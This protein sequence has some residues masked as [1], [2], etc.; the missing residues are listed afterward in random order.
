MCEIR[1]SSSL[2]ATTIL[3]SGTPRRISLAA[4]QKALS[5]S[6]QTTIGSCRLCRRRTHRSA[7]RSAVGLPKEKMP[8]STHLEGC[9]PLIAEMRRVELSAWKGK[10]INYGTQIMS[11]LIPTVLVARMSTSNS[12]ASSSDTTIA[13]F[14]LSISVRLPRTTFILWTR[15]IANI[16]CSVG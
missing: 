2:T 4:Q 15:P 3:E 14:S 1:G 8:Q 9:I 16:S 11:T 10:L 5:A 6:P 7:S 13:L 12:I